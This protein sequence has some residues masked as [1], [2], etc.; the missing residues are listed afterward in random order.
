M[1]NAIVFL[2]WCALIWAVFTLGA[3]LADGLDWWER[4]YD[5]EGVWAGPDPVRWALD[6]WK[7]LRWFSWQ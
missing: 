4:Q 2:A 7:W 3:L 5:D 1:E 6:R